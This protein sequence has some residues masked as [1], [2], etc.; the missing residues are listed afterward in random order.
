MMAAQKTLE[1]KGPIISQFKY[2]RKTDKTDKTFSR[3]PT[4]LFLLRWV[5]L[6][7]TSSIAEKKKKK[8]TKALRAN[9]N[10][11]VFERKTLGT[12]EKRTRARKETNFL[13][14][15]CK[16]FNKQEVNRACA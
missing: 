13:F 16:F 5:L 1:K 6:P 10:P 11:Y 7:D 12:E 4:I 15:Y 14:A 9:G 2:R 3:T 8:S